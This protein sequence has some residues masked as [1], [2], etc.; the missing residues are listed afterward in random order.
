MG[1]RVNGLARIDGS[2]AG[3]KRVHSQSAL[4]P[5]LRDGG[6]ARRSSNLLNL[7]ST[8]AIVPK[9]SSISCFRAS[10]SVIPIVLEIFSSFLDRCGENSTLIG[11]IFHL[12][13]SEYL[14][15][16]HEKM[17]KTGLRMDKFKTRLSNSERMCKSNFCA[18]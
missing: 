13:S 18:K 2:F 14:V 9:S 1:F 5:L 10:F 15:H 7:S 17:L 4:D 12:D 16:Y 6:R 8:F 3:A 11:V